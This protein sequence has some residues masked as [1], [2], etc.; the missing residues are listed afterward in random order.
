MTVF[1][2]Y[3]L[4][5]VGGSIALV[6]AIIVTVL[7]VQF[8]GQYGRM[9]SELSSNLQRLEQLHQRD[10]FPSPENVERVSENLE[11]LENY[12]EG[13]L[14][15]LSAQQP[16]IEDMERAA[17]PP[18]IE[19]TVRRLRRLAAQQEV[20]IAETVAF[21]FGRYA[22]GNLPMQEHVRRLVNQLQTIEMLCEI[23]FQAQIN[24]LIRVEREIFDVERTQREIA[25]DMARR[26]RT[27]TTDDVV[28]APTTAVEP[29]GVEGL[30]TKERYTLTF[31]ASDQALRMVLNQLVAHPVMMVV[32]NL[33]LQNE[34]GVGGTSV[35]DR[36]AQRLRPKETREAAVPPGQEV[37]SRADLLHEDRIVAGLERV[38]VTMALDVYRFGD[39]PVAGEGD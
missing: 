18:E 34:M 25:P 21:G 3:M 7:L 2:K 32:R 12:L 38:R 14:S 36:L 20:Q 5:V 29:E 4:L 23:L 17:F 19:R 8:S 27:D 11:D 28:A 30:Y 15:A 39:Q 6:L 9:Q 1:R 37:P 13:M 35:A 22:G 16:A 10:P 31:F 33:E 24:E 26:R